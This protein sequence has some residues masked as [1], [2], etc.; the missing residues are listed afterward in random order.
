M[1]VIFWGEKWKSVLPAK[2]V[3]KAGVNEEKAG[4]N[5]GRPWGGRC[6]HGEGRLTPYWM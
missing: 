2:M 6:S 1:I 3:R 5:M 4:V